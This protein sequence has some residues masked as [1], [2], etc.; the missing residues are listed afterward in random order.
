MKG[1]VLLNSIVPGA[2]YNA[3]K[4][5][6]FLSYTTGL[7]GK[8]NWKN[9]NIELVG[10]LDHGRRQD[11]SSY[12]DVILAGEELFFVPCYQ[13]DI[14]SVCVYNT[15]T[16][17]YSYISLRRSKVSAEHPSD[18]TFIRGLFIG[19]HIYLIPTAYD[20]IVRINVNTHNVEYI[21]DWVN[22]FEE[23]MA[24]E[25]TFHYY[26]FVSRQYVLNG[27]FLYLPFAAMRAILKLNVKTL[28]EEIICIDVDSLGFSCICEYENGRFWLTGCCE[29]QNWLYLWDEESNRI[30]KRIKMQQNMSRLP[31]IRM[32]RHRNKTYLLPWQNISNESLDILY[33]NDG[34]GELKN[35]CLLQDN[36]N[37]PAEKM[38]L[39]FEIVYASDIDD[40]KLR[41]VRG[42]DLKWYE[43]Q[44]D[45]MKLSEIDLRMDWNYKKNKKIIISYYRK[46]LDYKMP[47]KE[48]ELGLQSFLEEI[49]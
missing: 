36:K 12:I 20:A 16:E 39:E 44:L 14:L 42:R 31:V 29:N 47:I 2:S 37:F 48:N 19:E 3:E 9:N 8:I 30:M 25:D 18:L 26:G 46:Y 22:Q 5:P 45:M 27:D 21:D 24:K 49:V 34:E 6:W 38:Q 10:A 23:M 13:D 1:N 7:F 33:I 35:T 43:C 41:F 15:V 32:Y 28:D 17:R 4:N 40:G 11:V